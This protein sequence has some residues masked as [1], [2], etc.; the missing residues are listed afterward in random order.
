L[1]R[2]LGRLSEHVLAEQQRPDFQPGDVDDPMSQHPYMWN[3]NN[4]VEYSDPSGCCLEDACVVE[5][6][7]TIG[8]VEIGVGVLLLVGTIVGSQEIKGAGTGLRRQID[9]AVSGAV[10]AAGAAFAHRNNARPSTEDKHQA[11]ER[12]SGIDAGGE[13]G[14]GKRTPPRKRPEVWKGPPPT[15]VLPKVTPGDRVVAEVGVTR[16]AVLTTI[17]GIAR[18]L[19]IETTR[20]QNA[21]EGLGSVIV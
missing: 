10:S 4:P 17:P 21:E 5:G 14:D 8:A 7:V 18:A 12:R 1:S 15:A 20:K 2:A 11:G 3:A 9:S 16:E 19:Q 13:K 6:E